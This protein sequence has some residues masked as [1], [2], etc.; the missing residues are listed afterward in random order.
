MVI[1]GLVTI[2]Y[3]VLIVTMIEDIEQG[4]RARKIYYILLVLLAIMIVLGIIY[5][6]AIFRRKIT[7]YV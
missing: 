4:Y 1:I 6:Q 2:G 5:K 3:L 7:E